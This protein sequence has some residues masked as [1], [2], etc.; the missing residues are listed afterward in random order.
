MR[1]VGTTDLSVFPIALG[2]NVFGWTADKETSFAVLDEY[3][4]NGG[5]FLDTADVYPYWATG[6]SASEMIIGEWLAH[7][8]NRDSLVLST[9]VGMLE[10][11][12]GLAPA[13]IRT[14]V[15]DSLRRLRTDYIDLYWAHVDDH[16]TPMVESLAVFDALV[17]EGKI[18]Y[19]GASNHSAARL[20]EALKI[21]DEEGLVR[22]VALQQEYNLVE[23]GYEGELRDVVAK[24]RLGSTPYFGLARGFLTGK[25][26]PG[27][28]VESPRAG[29]AGEYLATEHG[30]RTLEAL[31]KVAAERVVHP[32]SVA[33]AWLAAQPTIT[34]PIASARSVE[35][36]QALI[37]AAELTL[38]AEELALLDEASR[39]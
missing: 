20:A 21:S 12:R 24:E 2:T 31:T 4:E 37:T 13:T 10:G 19:A 15:E 28:T 3:V 39:P 27:V 22:Y 34:A 35:Q 7:R 8:H 36:L 6:D 14:A 26:A 32:A 23:R 16:D 33:L 29:K 17:R 1:S 25:Y 18:R 9:K 38:S 30:R 5:N 11:L